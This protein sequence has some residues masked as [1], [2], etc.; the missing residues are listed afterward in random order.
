MLLIFYFL[1]FYF[2]L[3]YFLFFDDDSFFLFLRLGLNF[4]NAALINMIANT[5]VVNATFSACLSMRESVGNNF[6]G[7]CRSGCRMKGLGAY[8]SG[9]FMHS[10][11]GHRHD[12][13]E[14]RDG[15]MVRPF[16]D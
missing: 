4:S 10:E 12:V 9:M 5:D 15:R 8:L 6:H 2:V 11:Y 1:P 3:F 14:T 13:R 16:T 7:V